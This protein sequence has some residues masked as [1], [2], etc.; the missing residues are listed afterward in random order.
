M[1]KKSH[2]FHK[3][4]LI[5]RLENVLG[6]TLGEVDS[7]HVFNKTKENP[8]ITG[9]AG[10]VIEQS[11]LGL[12]PD[13]GQ[14][15]DLNVDGVEVEL[16]TTGI[17]KAKKEEVYEA[18]EPMSI[19]AVSPEQIT[20]EKF[21]T[22]KF[23]R[24]LEHTLLVYYLYASIEVVPAHEYAKFPIKGY[25]F[26]EFSKEDMAR[27]KCDWEIVR[28][29]LK[30]IQENHPEP[31]TEYPR[32]SSE[33]RPRLLYIDT[34]PKWPN[35]PRFRLKRQVVTSI[36]QN[37]FSGSL[38]QL[39]GR[40]SSYDDIDRKC[41]ELA[42]AYRGKTIEELVESLDVAWPE[43]KGQ[44]KNC[45]ER[46]IVRMFGGTTERISK[47]ELF[48]KI[49]LN[50]KTITVTATGSRTEDMKLFPIDFS[51]WSEEEATF[52]GSAL[53]DYFANHQ[54]LCSVFEEPD[55]NALLSQNKF[56][57]FK[58]FYFSEEFIHKDVK[59]IW[60]EVRAL[61]QER[62]LT[63]TVVLDKS[64]AARKNKAGTVRTQLNFPKSKDGSVFIRGSGTDSTRKPVQLNG[65]AMY[66]QYV[67]VKGT[68]IVRELKGIPFL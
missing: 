34:A 49:G 21:E 17:R 20:K 47:I 38:E 26:H 55:K 16:K 1:E 24:K 32:L 66:R 28:D 29:F 15:P 68:Y 59:K 67:W 12:P 14:R 4:E 40:Y 22:S 7:K 56:L 19:T 41:H 2:F 53:Y 18:K 58:R 36:V 8:K 23:W 54:F 48:Q 44:R 57:G 11:V 42:Q 64:G 39:P 30:E 62:R 27:L 52:E 10:D 25:E 35:P 43:D 61:I 45:A 46:I 50:S 31:E 3:A 60:E 9:I 51:E 33:L 6:K 63:E 5:E 37:H 65:I 13:N